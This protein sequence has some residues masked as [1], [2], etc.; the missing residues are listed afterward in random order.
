M[1]FDKTVFTMLVTFVFMECLADNKKENSP[2]MNDCEIERMLSSA[3]DRMLSPEYLS[4]VERKPY[5]FV[6]RYITANNPDVRNNAIIFCKEM[7]QEWCYPILLDALHDPVSGNRAVAA[8]A[9]L[10]LGSQVRKSDLFDAIA[11]QKNN[12]PADNAATVASLILAIGCA[13]S[14]QKG[15][16]GNVV[17]KRVCDFAIAALV[18][19]DPDKKLLYE[20]RGPFPYSRKELDSARVVY[21]LQASDMQQENSSKNK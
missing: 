10:N 19:I 6:R 5:L 9:I 12:F 14:W 21:G 11:W 3:D 17:Y 16:G 20:D 1:S 2:V 18:V 8:S 15:R 13:G 7:N 4:K